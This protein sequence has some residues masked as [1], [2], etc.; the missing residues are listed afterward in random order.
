MQ[1][2]NIHIDT[3]KGDVVKGNKTINNYRVTKV[4]NIFN[5]ENKDNI[6]ITKNW[7]DTTKPFAIVLGTTTFEDITYQELKNGKTFSLFK[8]FIYLPDA[9][10]YIRF[11]VDKNNLL[12]SN[13]IIGFG[14]H[15]FIA[16]IR[17]NVPIPN[18]NRIFNGYYSSNSIEIFDAEY[19]IPAFQLQLRKNN[20]IFIA[21]TF[22][23]P[24]GWIVVSESEGW[25][26][27]FFGDTINRMSDEKRRQALDTFLEQSKSIK[28]IYEV[29]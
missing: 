18:S 3:V 13:D 4:Y 10:A 19:N 17:D 8:D 9:I 16:K 12:I 6:L 29:Q 27:Q 14:E 24:K 25:K 2:Q 28:P 26:M 22:V 5:E 21:G 23:F 20:I 15:N 1:A 11:R 7:L